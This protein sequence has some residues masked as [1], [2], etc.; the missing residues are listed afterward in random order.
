MQFLRDISSGKVSAQDMKRRRIQYASKL[1][2]AFIARKTGQIAPVQLIETSP[3]GREIVSDVFS[4]AIMR[5]S[6]NEIGCRL[7][8]LSIVAFCVAIP[9]LQ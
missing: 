3:G 1:G 7:D 4:N 6:L 8:K 2:L 5:R 9:V